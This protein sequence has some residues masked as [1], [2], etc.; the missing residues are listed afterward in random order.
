MKALNPS[1]CIDYTLPSESSIS[2]YLDALT[3]HQDY[4]VSFACK[5]PF[6]G[7]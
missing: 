4:W 3:A 7:R 1:G 2:Q 5:N 6:P